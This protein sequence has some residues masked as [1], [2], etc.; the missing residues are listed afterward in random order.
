MLGTSP[1]CVADFVG[2]TSSCA[3]TCIRGDIEIPDLV[4]SSD[5][6]IISSSHQHPPMMIQEVTIQQSEQP[7]REGDCTSY[8]Q[9]TSSSRAASKSG[10]TIHSCNSII[11]PMTILL[12]LPPL[13]PK[14]NANKKKVS[15][16]TVEVHYHDV[17]LGDNPGCTEGPPIQIG[18]KPFATNK[19]Q[20]DQFEQW[21]EN[22]RRRYGK[23]RLPLSSIQRYLLLKKTDSCNYNSQEIYDRVDEMEAIKK[24]RKR[25]TSGYILRMRLSNIVSW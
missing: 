19:F 3:V 14:E 11:R 16:D 12:S 2:G 4:P 6:A 23:S 21:R 24:Q 17:I 8:N 18:W 5:D 22:H 7:G 1:D 13:V 15:F 9:C 20:I 10:P 25:S